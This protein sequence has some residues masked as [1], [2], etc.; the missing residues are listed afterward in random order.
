MVNFPGRT[1]RR[2]RVLNEEVL[3]A[4]SGRGTRAVSTDHD[5]VQTRRYSDAAGVENHPQVTDFVP[6]KY[7]SI[8]MLVAMGVVTCGALG[9]AHY[10]APSI[11]AA[12][13]M[14]TLRPFDLGAP[15]SI[16]AWVSAVVLFIASAA[17][18]LVYSIRR[19]R[20]DDF[21]GRYR[22][23]LAASFACLVL[24]VDSVAWLHHVV[25]Y[26]LSHLIGWTAL[27]DGAVWWI[28]IAGLPLAWIAIRALMDVRECRLALLFFMVA[29]ACFATA[30][31]S[32]FAGETVTETKNASLVTG[33]TILLGHWLALAAVVTYARYVVLDAQGLVAVRPVSTTQIRTEEKSASTVKE[34]TSDDSKPTVLSVVNYART[35][36][37]ERNE[38]DDR[39]VDGRRPER[40][41]YKKFDEEEEESSSDS[42]LSKTDRKRLRKLKAQNRAA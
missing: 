11:A 15:G 22:V 20:I 2:R 39:W 41:S 35:K 30:G 21:R 13:G 37:A 10:F 33:T 28:A 36:S 31:A 40:N 27:R 8:G 24:S 38:D 6:R 7:R 17:C 1:G 9:A 32:F 19:H 3:S 12:A 29:G 4:S 26:S 16:A 42:K 5:P 14:P 34:M 25:A 23:W 18:L